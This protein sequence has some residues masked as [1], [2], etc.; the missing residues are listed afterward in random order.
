ML[1]QTKNYPVE[2][3]SLR[4]KNKPQEVV[5]SIVSDFKIANKNYLDSTDINLWE[6]KNLQSIPKEK[7]IFYESH[8]DEEVFKD[9][10]PFIHMLKKITV[11]KPFSNGKKEK[12][13]TA[14]LA[15]DLIEDMRSEKRRFGKIS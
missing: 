9:L 7:R 15:N 5:R 4:G 3:V 1:L 14:S 13:R 6:E 10:R 2:K 12:N 11:D 8:Y